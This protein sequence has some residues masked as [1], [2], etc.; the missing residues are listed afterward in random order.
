MND[1]EATDARADVRIVAGFPAGSPDMPRSANRIE[2]YTSQ[3][4]DEMG[5]EIVR[6][7]DELL[8]K[9]DAV[10][11]T[12]VDGRPHLEQIKPVFRARK[13]VFLDKPV[14]ADLADVVDIYRLADDHDVPIFSSSCRRFTP[15]V[16]ELCDPE[17]IGEVLGCDTFSQAYSARHHTE[18]NFT[19]MH[20][21]AMLYAIMGRGCEWVTHVETPH[22]LQVTGMWHDGRVGAW[23]GIR[24]GRQRKGGYGAT[25]FGR[26]GVAA[27]GP[28]PHYISYKPLVI[29]IAKFFKTG[30]PPVEAETT[31]EIYAYL[32]AAEQSKRRAGAPVSIAEVLEK[33]RQPAE[34]K[35]KK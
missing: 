4:R 16:R 14:A 5:V 30:I 13:P 17:K 19:G 33:A 9:V 15:G 34:R 35:E 7:I 18:L 12:S 31:I 6:S 11:L 23:R 3:L 8:Q 2:N 28:L 10:L 32:E 1:K 20:G 21:V 25:I 26:K 22:T 27:T 29:E 24:T